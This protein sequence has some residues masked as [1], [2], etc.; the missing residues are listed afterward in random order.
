MAGK[1]YHTSLVGLTLGEEIDNGGDAEAIR[2]IVSVSHGR[3]LALL[4]TRDESETFV[5]RRGD[6]GDTVQLFR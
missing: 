4:P 2:S 5:T 6:G 3:C 1:P